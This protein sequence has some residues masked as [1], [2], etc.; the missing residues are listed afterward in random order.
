MR[1]IGGNKLTVYDVRLQPSPHPDPT[2]TIHESLEV[3]TN[4][5]EG[6]SDSKKSPRF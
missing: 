2:V 3:E 1:T 4:A 5:D 6:P